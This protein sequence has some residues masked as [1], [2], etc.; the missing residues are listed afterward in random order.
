MKPRAQVTINQNSNSSKN[1][2]ELG[3]PFDAGFSSCHRLSHV[4]SKMH[5]GKDSYSMYKLHLHEKNTVVVGPDKPAILGSSCYKLVSSHH[6]GIC[7][8]CLAHHLALYITLWFVT[9]RTLISHFITTKHLPHQRQYKAR[10]PHF[11]LVH[12]HA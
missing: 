9:F 10:P 4:F 12:V 6:Q 7:T 11:I 8:T 2:H 5:L 3:V 1:S